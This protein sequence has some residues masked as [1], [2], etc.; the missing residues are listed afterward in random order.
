MKALAIAYAAA[1]AAW[2]VMFSP[3]T[4]GQVNFW[5]AMATAAGG[6]AACGFACNRRE[7]RALFGFKTAWILIG[8]VSA[9]VLYLVFLVG[10]F[11]STRIL[12]F[13]AGQVQD[14]YALGQSVSPL[15]K[16]GLLLWIA[17]CEEIFWRG[18]IQHRL[19]QRVGRWRGWLLAAGLYALPHLWS[20]NF[21]LVMA[22]LLCGLLWGAVTAKYKSLWPA[23][24]SHTLWDVTI[25]VLL[26]IH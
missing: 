3:W 25:F 7:A 14:I 9:A 5:A 10:H 19:T 13:A 2:L 12:G 4:A 24:I 22:A 17:P 23:I 18:F 21:M 20:L 1:L 26:P 15:A 16:V 8:I 6:L 11:T